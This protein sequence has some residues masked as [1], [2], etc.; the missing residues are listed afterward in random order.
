VAVIERTST[1]AAGVALVDG[2]ALAVGDARGEGETV[3]VIGTLLA[4][5]PHATKT[6]PAAQPSKAGFIRDQ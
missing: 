4:D 3:A 6:A 5:C 2:D 1:D